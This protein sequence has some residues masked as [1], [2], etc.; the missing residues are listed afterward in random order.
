MRGTLRGLT[1]LLALAVVGCNSGG[2]SPATPSPDTHGTL[3]LEQSPLPGGEA[4]PAGTGQAALGGYTLA[5]DPVALTGEATMWRRGSQTDDT[6]FLSV[7]NFLQPSS[8]QVTGVKADAA[9]LIL[10]YTFTHPFKAPINLAGPATAANRADLGISARLLLLNDVPAGTAAAHTYFSGEAIAN[11][12]LMV[13]ADG[14]YQPKG[15]LTNLTGFAANTFPYKLVVDEGAGTDGNRLGVSNNAAGSGNYRV[16][17]GGWQQLNID[18]SGV[19]NGWTGFDYLHQGQSASGQFIF[20]KTLLF[21][22]PFT[23]DVAVLAKYI[24]PRG[25][26]TAATKRANRLPPASPDVAKFV[27]RMP[28]GAIDCG[29]VTY[30]GESGGLLPNSPVS[31]TTVRFHVRDWDAR[32]T[33]TS[34]TDLNDEPDPSFIVPGT[35]GVPTVLVDVPGVTTSPA[36]LAVVDDDSAYGGDPGVDEGPARDELFFTGVVQNSAG[37]SGQ[38]N[39]TKIGLVKVVDAANSADRSAYEFSLDPTLTPLTANQPDL[40]TY[41]AIDV[42]L[43]GGTT[44]DPPTATVRI[45]TGSTPIVASGGALEIWLEAESD[46]ESNPVLYDIDWTNDGSFDVMAVDPAGV[47]PPDVLIDGSGIAPT[48]S[49]ASNEAH[50][51]RVRFDDAFSPAAPTVVL[52]DYLV[53]PVGANTPPS[54]SIVLQSNNIPSGGTLTYQ[55]NTETDADGDTVTYAI[56]YDLAGP[57]TPDVSGLDPSAPP[58][59]LHVSTAQFNGS[60][61][62]ASRTTR[63]Q[64]SDGVN[65]AIGVNLTYTLGPSTGCTAQTQTWDFTSGTQGW[66]QGTGFSLSP[67]ANSDL[68]GWGHFTRMCS[69][70][71]TEAQS[72]GAITGGYWTSGDDGDDSSCSFL[73]DYGSTAN[74]NIVSPWINVPTICTAGS[75]QVI[76]NAYLFARAGASAEAYISTDQGTSWGSPVW[77]ATATGNEQV[78]SNTAVSLPDTL[79]G[80]TILLR[81]RF[82]DP[83]ASTWA[84]PSPYNTVDNN[85]GCAIDNIRITAGATG[86]FTNN[87]PTFPCSARNLVFNFD[88]SAQGWIGGES[89]PY[90][91]PNGDDQGFAGA[92]GYSAMRWTDCNASNGNFSAVTT[93]TAGAITGSSLNNLNDGTAQFCGGFTND[94]SGLPNHNT[95]SPRIYIPAN[96]AGGTVALKWDAYLNTDDS[97]YVDAFWENGSEDGP[98]LS[99]TVKGYLSTNNGQ[100]WTVIWAQGATGTSQVFLNQNVDITSYAANAGGLRVRFEYVGTDPDLQMAALTDPIGFYVDNV[101]LESTNTNSVYYTF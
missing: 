30:L 16:S 1:A 83:T 56:D 97:G 4:M 31:S 14:Y 94:H 65:P 62:P 71:N 44:N 80:Q 48:N 63:I 77:S 52:L 19:N 40:I 37:T 74:Y 82:T 34:R 75:L 78:L 53:A 42:A 70:T 89:S 88:T 26:T 66:I 27:Y 86:P 10:N 39:S 68:T 25:G 12:G 84:L 21:S 15:L 57:F 36:T 3:N 46:P 7:D 60:A 11:A 45:N 18:N 91:L 96:C 50:Q 23:L 76:F 20:D 100:T 22:G 32:G 87:P 85:G 8:L 72:G 28:H 101:R 29:H 73:Y 24:D 51:A 35:E 64:Y 33:V 49:T 69:T 92:G 6:Y 5:I 81:F 58:T 43:G 47:P 98:D 9:N 93:A 61:S 67:L 90:P 59:T 41:Q 95:V 99:V 2:K 17:D 13:N 55:L 79:A 38:V 54:A